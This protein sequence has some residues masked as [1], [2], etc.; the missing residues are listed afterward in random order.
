MDAELDLQKL[1]YADLHTH[2]GGCTSHNLLWELS[3]E[4]GIKINVKKYWDFI[5]LMGISKDID[6]QKYLD[7]FKLTH[8]IQSSPMAVE[9]TIYNAISQAYRKSNI[10][11]LEI[12]FNP[13]FRSN[14]NLYDID[15]IIMA[16]IVGMQKGMMIYPV[17]VG[18]ILETDRSFTPKMSS[19]I[20][21]K[22][23]KYRHLGVVGF[24][25]SGSNHNPSFHIK[26]HSN[27]F[28]IAKQGGL[29]IT[30]HAGETPN[31]SSEMIEVLEY[32]KPHRI[33]HGI[34]LIDDCDILQGIK[35]QSIHLELCPTSNFIT[36][37]S[38][39]EEYKTLIT[40]LLNNGIS[41]SLNSDGPEFLKT[42]VIKEYKK[43]M[44]SNY[45]EQSDIPNIQKNTIKA[46][47]IKNH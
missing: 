31:S 9:R 14:Q 33:G 4:Q 27:S 45:I 34:R 19:I 3:H 25:M 24:D 38:D 7:K 41:F 17:K 10:T 35:E 47:F 1:E 18:I 23:I 11:L 43:L 12:R 16:A 15:H 29:G 40:T 21:T 44:E 6:H 28:E 26:D 39:M 42:S 37:V 30:V 2:L 13:F 46:S 8:A 36:K 32:I 22:A 5:E 20:A